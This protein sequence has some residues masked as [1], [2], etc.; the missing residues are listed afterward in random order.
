MPPH[1]S[2]ERFLAGMPKRWVPQVVNQRQRFDKI[3]I[4]FELRGHRARNLGNFNGVSQPV[5]KVI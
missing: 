2:V 5:A 4:Q 3:N 1:G